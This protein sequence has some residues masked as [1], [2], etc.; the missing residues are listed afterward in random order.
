MEAAAHGQL[1]G[2]GVWR[3]PVLMDGGL[4]AIWAVD[5]FGVVRKVRTIRPGD[6]EMELGDRLWM[7]L[8]KHHP[9]RTLELVRDPSPAPATLVKHPTSRRMIDA[10]LLTDPHSPL[11]KQRYLARLVGNAA[12]RLRRFDT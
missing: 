11:V 2:Y 3:A 4:P 9:E 10:R 6:D 5:S 8:R 7:W 12:G 1:F